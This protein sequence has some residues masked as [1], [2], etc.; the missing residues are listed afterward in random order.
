MLVKKRLIATTNS[1]NFH[2]SEL[3]ELDYQSYHQVFTFFSLFIFMFFKS[4]FSRI[5]GIGFGKLIMVS[6]SVF[7]VP[8]LFIVF[9]AS[10][11]LFVHLRQPFLV[12]KAYK[13]KS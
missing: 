9:H 6:Y 2:S 4:V 5:Y 7:S 1:D 11:N 10:F 13:K 3:E 12:Q 8:P